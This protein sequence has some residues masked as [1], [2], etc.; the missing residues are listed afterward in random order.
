MGRG[1]WFFECFQKP[2]CEVDIIQGLF[3]KSLV[4]ALLLEDATIAR[5]SHCQIC[6]DVEKVRADMLKFHRAP[7]ALDEGVCGFP[8]N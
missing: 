3:G 7:K 2:V 4:G 6:N 5:Q 1:R 8:V